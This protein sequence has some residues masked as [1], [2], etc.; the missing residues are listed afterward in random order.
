MSKLNASWHST[1]RMPANAT[2]DQRVQWHQAHAVACGCREIP[3]SIREELE[4][5][6]VAVARR[7]RRE[8]P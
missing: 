8:K 4:R 6:G 7:S 3:K 5:R 2:L 1:H